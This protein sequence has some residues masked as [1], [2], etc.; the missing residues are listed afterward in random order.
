MENS[1]VTNLSTPERILEAAEALFA[2]RGYGDTSVRDITVLAGTNLA[3]VNYHFGGKENLYV[4]V[5]RRVL[6]RLREHRIRGLEELLARP[7]LTL[8]TVLETFSRL[9]LEPL[10]GGRGRAHVQLFLWEMLESH[11]P[12]WKTPR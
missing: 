6:K 8:E 12:P 9:F 5:F 7:D 11:L 1:E 3:S 10:E 4:A 2:A